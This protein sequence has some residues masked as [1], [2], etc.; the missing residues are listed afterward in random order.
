M[1]ALMLAAALALTAHAAQAQNIYLDSHTG[2]AP[3]YTAPWS[4][5]SSS[6]TPLYVP[7]SPSVP[8]VQSYV[9]SPSQG[10]SFYPCT[11]PLGCR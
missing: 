4:P 2:P 10:P 7:P 8:R 9:P 6:Y 1:K 3:G 11:L 5:P